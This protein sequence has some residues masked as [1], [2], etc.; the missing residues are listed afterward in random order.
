MENNYLTGGPRADT[1]QQSD[2]M[3]GGPRINRTHHNLYNALTPTFGKYSRHSQLKAAKEYANRSPD[4]YSPTSVSINKKQQYGSGE[5]Y[6]A[7]HKEH[8]RR[9]IGPGGF[10]LPLVPGALAATTRGNPEPL[11]IAD[12]QESVNSS[13]RRRPS[14]LTED[15]ISQ[16]NSRFS[17]SV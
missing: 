6:K 16:L 9:K 12:V 5:H 14:I 4:M 15:E 13:L 7:Y 10:H 8:Q 1:T 17:M 11:R 2:T 3:H